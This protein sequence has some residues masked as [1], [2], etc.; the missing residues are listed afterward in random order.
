MREFL[1]IVKSEGIITKEELIPKVVK[2]ISNW[3]QRIPS[4]AFDTISVW[5]D[6]LV[7]RNLYL[8]L[9]KYKLGNGLST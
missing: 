8:D 6:I 9:Y 4:Y 7:A 1:S 2:S 3:S 5:D